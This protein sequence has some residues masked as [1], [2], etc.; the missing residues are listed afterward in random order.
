MPV[1]SLPEQTNQFVV[2]VDASNSRIGS[3]LSQ[4]SG[5]DKRIHP[6]ASLSTKLCLAERNYSI[7]DRFFSR[8]NFTLCYLPG[9]KNVKPDNLS[10]SPESDSEIHILPAACIT[11]EVERKVNDS[12]HG[13]DIDI[14]TTPSSL[15]VHKELQG[16]MI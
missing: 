7:R 11:W 13:V 16:Q 8:L 15:F 6:C 5:K 12:I 1:L 4:C 3:N 10:L 14:A 9:S 2:E